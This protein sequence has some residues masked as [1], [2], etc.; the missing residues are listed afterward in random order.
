VVAA[1]RLGAAKG[2]RL[3]ARDPDEVVCRSPFGHLIA[4]GLYYASFP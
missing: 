1:A 4:A 3:V 2:L